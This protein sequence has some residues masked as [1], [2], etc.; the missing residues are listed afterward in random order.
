MELFPIRSETHKGEIM[1][2]Q[3]GA[4]FL[5]DEKKKMEDRKEIREKFPHIPFPDPVLEPIYYGR[6]HKTPVEG[7]KLIRDANSANGA[8]YAIVS[9]KYEKVHHE[10]VLKNLISAI[11]DEFGEPVFDINLM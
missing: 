2:D 9:D 4:A 5:Q 6:T 8:Q 3:T 1:I 10:D 11:P 7:K